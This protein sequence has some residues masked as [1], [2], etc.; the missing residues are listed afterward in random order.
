MNTVLLDRVQSLLDTSAAG[1]TGKQARRQFFSPARVN[2]IGE[3]IDYCGGTVLPAAIRFGTYLVAQPNDGDAVR[4]ASL[5]QPGLVEFDP[6]NTLRRE[7]AIHWGDY[8]KGIYAE[9][10][11]LGVEL[12]CLDIAIG[13]DIPG[14][15]LSSS[16]SLEIGIAVMIEA[17][18]GFAAADDRLANRRAMSR[19][20]QRAENDFVGVRCGIMDQAAIALGRDGHAMLLDCSDLSVRYVPIELGRHQLLIVNT[21]KKRTLA[22]SAYNRRREEVAQALVTLQARFQIEQLCELPVARLDD[23][24]DCIADPALARRARHVIT[25]QDRVLQAAR[26]LADNDVAGFGGLLNASHRS[27]QQDFEVTGLE[28]DTLIELSQAQPGVLGA[29]MTGAGFGGCGLVLVEKEAI[30]DFENAVGAGYRAK[31]GYDAAFYPVAIGAGADEIPS[32][33]RGG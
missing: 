32:S 16:A 8:V 12:P 6:S 7:D 3:H 22:D 27:L 25:E 20:A 2:L 15:G 10:G 13:G 31:I 14:G 23:A 33:E 21:C 18:S 26:C 1:H 4:A 5:N 9:Y 28:L 29:R 30:V 24:L 17:F 19:L 11:A